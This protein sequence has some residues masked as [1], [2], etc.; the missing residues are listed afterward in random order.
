LKETQ[1]TAKK[2][3]TMD[4]L[5][6]ESQHPRPSLAQRGKA[7]PKMSTAKGKALKVIFF[8]LILLASRDE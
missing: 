6:G 8:T 1:A 4:G 7:V 2:A 3:S 5:S